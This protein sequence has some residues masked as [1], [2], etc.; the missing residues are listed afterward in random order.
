MKFRQ[1]GWELL[2]GR[3][4]RREEQKWGGKDGEGEGGTV[5]VVCFALKTLKDAM[6]LPI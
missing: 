3:V 2:H 5:S 1:E 4:S 6:V